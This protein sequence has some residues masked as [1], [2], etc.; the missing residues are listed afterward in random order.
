MNSSKS[1]FCLNKIIL[2]EKYSKLIAFYTY[3]SN[4]YITFQVL[5]LNLHS[6]TRSIFNQC[7]VVIMPVF[8]L[9]KQSLEHASYLLRLFGTSV[10]ELY[11]LNPN[12]FL[13]LLV[14]LGAKIFFTTINNQDFLNCI[15]PLLNWGFPG[16]E[17]AYNAGDPHSIPGL[18]RSPGEGIGYPL[19]CSGLEN[20]MGYTVHGVTK[21]QTQLS[22]F[23]FSLSLKLV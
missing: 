21:S 15:T 18:R 16:K 1:T 22:H 23:H 10:A 19:Q 2:L 17:T 9:G 8:Q 13:S 14:I 7:L 6:I 20:S 3:M 11:L 5:S 4:I 12:L